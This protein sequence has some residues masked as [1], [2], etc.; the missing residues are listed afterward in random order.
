MNMNLPSVLWHRWSGVRKSIWPVKIEWW[1]VVVVICCC[2]VHCFGIFGWATGRAYRRQYYATLSLAVMFLN[3]WRKTMEREKRLLGF[4][5]RS[6]TKAEVISVSLYSWRCI[7]CLSALVTCPLSCAVEPF[8]SVNRWHC[9]FGYM[10][11][12]QPVKTANCFFQRY[13]LSR[14]NSFSGLYSTS[15]AGTVLQCCCVSATLSFKLH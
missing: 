12:I 15:A 14:C 11:L 9:C 5:W 10:Q 4:T 1:G 7:W 13:S 3:T 8:R 2:S 6:L